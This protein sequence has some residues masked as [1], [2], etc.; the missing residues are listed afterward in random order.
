[1]SIKFKA[2]AA[3]VVLLTV[4]MFL[5][6]AVRFKYVERDYIATL[7][8]T[9]NS[10]V[11]EYHAMRMR[12]VTGKKK[13]SVDDLS[14]F[15]KR[16]HKKYRNAALLAITDNSLSIRL[17]SKNDRYIRSADLF[18][19]I[20]K[21][22]T[23]EK[24]NISRN[25]PYTI[26]YYD[27]KTGGKVEQLK[28]YI[29]LNR[30][31][32][33]RLL[34]VY[35]YT[36]EKKMLARSALEMALITVFIIIITAALYIAM[37]KKPEPESEP[38]SY[39]IDLD[40]E[41]R[42]AVREDGALLRE[43]S[44]VA[45]DTLSGYIHDLFKKINKSYNTDSL[46]L[47][48]FHSS[49]RLVKTMEL[50]GRTFLRI[51]S[52]SFDTID[53]DNEAGRELRNGATMVLE[54]G[55]KIVIPLKYRDSF[56]GTV[57]MVRQKGLQGREIR[58]IKSAMKG[59]LKNI[60]DYITV[61]DVMTDTATGLHSKIYF[62]L[63]YNECMRSWKHKGKEFSI[64]VLMLFDKIEQIDV[65]EKNNIIKLLAPSVIDIIKDDGFICRYE[66]YLAILL[67]DINMRKAKRIAREIKS[68][69]MKYRIRIN[70]ESVVQI[71]P[72][73]GI[74][75][76]DTANADKDEDL[77]TLAIRQFRQVV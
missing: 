9:T 75:S 55:R 31:S 49:G 42:S 23:Q 56:L 72:S 47:Y 20:L 26:R 25:N 14:D 48:I 67:N 3:G 57:N 27:D 59:I 68:S 8:R 52:I 37:T 45:S 66:E 39:T 58:D 2:I 21:D 63:K 44:N 5:Y 13:L 38:T 16:T 46:S 73:I 30:I 34:V 29:F 32:G 15:L 53:I 70:V 41:N 1:M 17:S 71:V 51:D 69:L 35:P 50:K 11:Q 40:L 18:E 19:T 7:I 76:T 61:N 64:I 43:T 33:Y 77:V 65:N 6:F 36:F 22:F 60:H 24:F 62:N 54:D 74:S 10:I 28:F 4:S 12:P